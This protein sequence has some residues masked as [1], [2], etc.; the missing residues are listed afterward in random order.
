MSDK[1]LT[2]F[3]DSMT[4]SQLEQVNEFFE[5]MPKVRHEIKVKNP[6]TKKTSEVVLEGLADFF[7]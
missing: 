2:E 1:E 3:F 7:V 5:T 6:K 4:S